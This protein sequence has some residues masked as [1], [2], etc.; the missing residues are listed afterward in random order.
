[1]AQFAACFASGLSVNVDLAQ[2]RA[3]DLGLRSVGLLAK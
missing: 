1:M 2:A 3:D